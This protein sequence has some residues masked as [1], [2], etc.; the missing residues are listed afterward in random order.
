ML[1]TIHRTA[2]VLL[3]AGLSRR[4]GAQDKLLL[5]VAGEPLYAHALALMQ[6]LDVHDR[7]VVTNQPEIAAAAKHLGFAVV[8]NPAAAHGMGTSVAAGAAA[9]HAAV[10]Q[11]VFLN[12]DQPFLCAET[13]NTLLAAA[14]QSGKIIVPYANGKPSSPCVFPRRFF[15]ELAM[16]SGEQGGKAIWSRQPEAVLKLPIEGDA[17]DIDTPHD[18]QTMKKA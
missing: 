3:A 15:G 18:Y 8:P 6:T 9:L 1:D 7:L 10:T 14:M 17:R 4:M 13:V 5:P 2:A 11:A 16:L 12:A